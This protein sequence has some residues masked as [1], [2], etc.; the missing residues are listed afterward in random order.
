MGSNTRDCI[1][2]TKCRITTSLIPEAL[3]EKQVLVGGN[4]PPS[5][6]PTLVSTGIS[7][8]L[9]HRTKLFC[10]SCSQSYQRNGKKSPEK[11]TFIHLHWLRNLKIR[12]QEQPPRAST[13]Q[14]FL[15]FKVC[16]KCVVCSGVIIVLEVECLSDHF[17]STL[18][19][20]MG[21]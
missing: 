8:C 18:E 16:I 4:N 20:L 1:R 14:V 11:W 7:H 12:Y 19:P 9:H 3:S 5:L 6:T 2:T 15:E 13:V 10:S 17:R 21:W